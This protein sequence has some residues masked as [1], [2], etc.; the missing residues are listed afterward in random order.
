MIATTRYLIIL[1]SFLSLQPV[2]AQGQSVYDTINVPAGYKPPLNRQLVYEDIDREQSGILASDGKPD[3]QFTPTDKEEINSLLTRTLV[4]KVDQLQYGIETNK[5]FEHRIKVNYLTGLK[6]VLQYFRQNWKIKGEKKVNPIR[7]PEIVDAYIQ[8]IEEDRN[9][10]TIENIVKKLPY[11]AANTIVSTR[12][13]EKN[14]GYKKSKEEIILKY[15]VLHPE[16][17]LPVLRDNPDVSFADSLIRVVAKKFPRQL[18]D[19]AAANNKLGT[20]IR[21]VKDDVFIRTISQMATSKSGQQYFPFLDNIV[22]GKMTIAD[23]DDVKGDSLLYY[24]LLVNTHM[25]Y[26]SRA[27][28]KDT[29]FEYKGMANRVEVKARDF[30]NTIKGIHNE[31]NHK[32]TF[33]SIQT[34]K[35]KRP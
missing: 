14:V 31:R 5:A 3:K 8:C 34:L 18:Y 10:R 16:K 13:F 30:V 20:L 11:D 21:N 4:K 27:M 26:V 25:E 2:F 35:R 15:C 9:G 12:I 32:K 22:N 24:R 7:L 33:K 1:A 17:T 28:N 29:A 6:E 23:I 19:Y